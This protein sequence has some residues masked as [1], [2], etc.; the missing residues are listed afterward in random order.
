MLRAGFIKATL[1]AG[2]PRRDVQIAA[3]HADLRT[4]GICLVRSSSTSV[5]L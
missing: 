2:V 1:D 3:R 4:T 5:M